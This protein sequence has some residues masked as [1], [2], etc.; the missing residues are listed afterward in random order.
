MG[1]V[2]TNFR[3][4]DMLHSA[5]VTE[6]EVPAPTPASAPVEHAQEEPEKA[7]VKRAP[8]STKPKAEVDTN[9]GV[10]AHGENTDA[11]EHKE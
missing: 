4:K 5:D 6:P 3:A 10:P 8:R 9:S 1:K 2:Q 11:T 7:P